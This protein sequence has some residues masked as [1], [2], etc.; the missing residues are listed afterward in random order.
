MKVGGAY[1]GRGKGE[2][3]ALYFEKCDLADRY[4]VAITDAEGLSKVL[5]IAVVI[6]NLS[7]HSG[8]K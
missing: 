8:T 6:N 3:P 4:N 7:F 5:L 2:F 1:L